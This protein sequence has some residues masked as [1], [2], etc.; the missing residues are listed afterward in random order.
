M[1]QS[2]TT[3]APR[4]GRW[5]PTSGR[6]RRSPI[7][8]SAATRAGSRRTGSQEPRPSWRV[9]PTGFATPPPFTEPHWCGFTQPPPFGRQCP[10][11]GSPGSAIWL[12]GSLGPVVA[13]QAASPKSP[14]RMSM[15]VV[16]IRRLFS[17]RPPLGGT[18]VRLGRSGF[19]LSSKPTIQRGAQ[20]PDNRGGRAVNSWDAGVARRLSEKPAEGLFPAVV[21]VGGALVGPLLSVVDDRSCCR[22]RARARPATSRLGSLVQDLTE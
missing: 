5:H 14:L 21:S 4:C 11:G 2:I 18:G 17:A 19:L 10:C 8:A 16:D 9:T 13:E 20:V 22:I 1:T 12:G 7:S 6:S 3:V 15:R